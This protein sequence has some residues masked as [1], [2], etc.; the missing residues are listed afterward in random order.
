MGPGILLRRIYMDSVFRELRRRSLFYEL[1]D[2]VI[3]QHLEPGEQ[4]WVRKGIV[5]DL[6]FDAL[7]VRMSSPLRSA[8]NRRMK[9]RGARYVRKQGFRYFKGMRLKD[10]SQ[11]HLEVIRDAQCTKYGF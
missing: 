1:I 3:D 6:V 2:R 7:G 5:H 10:G 8:V 4:V 11:R 9:E